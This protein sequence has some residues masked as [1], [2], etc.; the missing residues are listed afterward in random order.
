MLEHVEVTAR[1]FNLGQHL[2]EVFDDQSVLLVDQATCAEV[3]QLDQQES[4]R[5]LVVLQSV[6]VPASAE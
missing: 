3:V 6:F 1:T 5:L 4:Y 2:L